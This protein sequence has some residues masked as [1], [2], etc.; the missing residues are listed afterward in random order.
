MSIVDEISRI[1]SNVAAAYSGLDAKGATMPQTQNTANLS[2]AIASLPNVSGK[3]DLAPVTHYTDDDTQWTQGQFLINNN[4]VVIKDTS[5]GM[6]GHKTLAEKAT[7][8]A[9]YGITD[10]YTK[11]QVDNLIPVVPSNVSSFINDAGYLTVHQNISGKE[12]ISDKVTAITSSC[13]NTQYPS[14]LAVKNYVDAVIGGIEN[15]SY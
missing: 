10:A 14:A 11:D 6:P 12:N 1:K 8:L 7:T 9:G 3:M 15:G 13:T 4:E 2:T 5:T